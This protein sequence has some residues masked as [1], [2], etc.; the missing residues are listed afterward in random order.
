MFKQIKINQRKFTT[1]ST[2]QGLAVAVERVGAEERDE[3]SLR[4][5]EMQATKAANLLEHSDEIAARPART[6]FQTPQQKQQ[7]RCTPAE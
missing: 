4:L 7:A 2:T 5:A 6:W 1:S 3:R